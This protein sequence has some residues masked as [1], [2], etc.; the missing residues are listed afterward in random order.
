VLETVAAV[1]PT[2]DPNGSDIINHLGTDLGAGV[3]VIGDGYA[4]SKIRLLYDSTGARWRSRD[5][6]GLWVAGT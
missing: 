4:G 3:T 5:T 1:T 2:I 6:S